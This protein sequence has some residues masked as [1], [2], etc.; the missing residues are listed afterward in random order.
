MCP[1]ARGRVCCDSKLGGGFSCECM[2]VVAIGSR[3]HQ[4]SSELPLVM[5]LGVDGRGGLSLCWSMVGVGAA[6]GCCCC[7]WRGPG[8]SWL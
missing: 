5:V 6:T 2:V 1:L 7:C 3:M 4:Q 8:H